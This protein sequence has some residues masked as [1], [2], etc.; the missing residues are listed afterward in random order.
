MTNFHIIEISYNSKSKQHNNRAEL[1]TQALKL[2]YLCHF[3]RDYGRLHHVK[4]SL[5]DRI[6]VTK[7]CKKWKK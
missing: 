6:F 3:K 4:F 1:Y 5:I 7:D 2:S